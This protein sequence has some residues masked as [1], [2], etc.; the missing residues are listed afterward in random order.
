MAS[1]RTPPRA[2]PWLIRRVQT[3]ELENEIGAAHI[4]E[5]C[6]NRSSRRQALMQLLFDVSKML[7]VAQIGLDQRVAIEP[8]WQCRGV[9]ARACEQTV[10]IAEDLGRLSS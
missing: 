4:A 1:E 9:R 6:E 8:R 3:I 7:A 10:E 5:Q 2:V